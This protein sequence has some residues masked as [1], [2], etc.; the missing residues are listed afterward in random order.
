MLVV[1]AAGAGF[2]AWYRAGHRAAPTALAT[3]PVPGAQER[4]QVEVLNA[5]GVTGLG[6]I[7]TQRL[8]DAGLDVV[9]FGSDTLARVLDSTQVVLRRGDTAAA[10][11]VRKALGAGAVSAAP[12][13]ARLVDVTVRLGA[14]FSALVRQP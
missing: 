6:R 5:S 10:A 9:Y 12:D 13:P 7:A 8:R 4:V 11:R 1:A 3:H 14:D 2:A